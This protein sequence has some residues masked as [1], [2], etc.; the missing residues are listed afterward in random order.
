MQEKVQNRRPN[1]AAVGLG[2]QKDSAWT[3]GRHNSHARKNDD[4]NY[5]EDLGGFGDSDDNDAEE[6][7]IGGFENR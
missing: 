7:D 3:A 2:Q 4:F 1:T 5:E 6:T